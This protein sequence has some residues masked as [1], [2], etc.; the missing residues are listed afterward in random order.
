MVPDA[1]PLSAAR[2]GAPPRGDALRPV[3]SPSARGET[4]AVV[5]ALAIVGT[6]ALLWI[7]R[8]TLGGGAG[9]AAELGFAP[10]QRAFATL[11]ADLQRDLRELHEAGEE[12]VRWRGDRGS[13]PAPAELAADSIAPFA[14]R[15]GAPPRRFERSDAP[16]LLQYLGHADGVR[17]LL[18][19]VMEPRPGEN[20]GEGGAP[21]PPDEQHRVLPDGKVLHVS[22]W[23][24]PTPQDDR[25]PR[26]AFL[27][28]PARH[29]FEQV[30][31]GSPAATPTAEAR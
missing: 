4:C 26:G 1:T 27:A 11:A 25:A 9:D 3:A 20:E 15:P 14:P 19:Q 17:S 6:L 10:W 7:S 22:Y 23:V 29:G 24:G 21:L 5:R 18:L 12:A 13:W 16:Y 31:F 28:D 8:G 2:Q 30:L